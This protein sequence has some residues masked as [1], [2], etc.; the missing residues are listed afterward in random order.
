MPVE[1]SGNCLQPLIGSRDT[2]LKCR[3]C[4]KNAAPTADQAAHSIRTTSF[5]CPILTAPALFEEISSRPANDAT[6]LRVHGI[7][8][9]GS[10]TEMLSPASKTGLPVIGLW[11]KP[12][13]WNN[14]PFGGRNGLVPWL[15]RFF[16]HG[17]GIALT[18]DR[19]SAPWWQDANRRADATL[20]VAGKIR[21]ERPDGSVG[22]SPGTGTTLFASGDRAVT[23]L[24][25]AEAFGL[26][27]VMRRIAA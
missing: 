7:P 12:F 25:R 18:P 5:H 26:G 22:K 6:W 27:A 3:N 23:A 19:T 24:V 11:G 17:N 10:V 13:L 14:P 8:L 1:D 21:F 4:L 20:F 16:G 15:D 9:N 2:G